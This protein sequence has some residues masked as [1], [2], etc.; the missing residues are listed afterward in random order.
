VRASLTHGNRQSFEDVADPTEATKRGFPTPR[1]F[2]LLKFDIVLATE[3]ETKEARKQWEREHGVSKG[4][5]VQR[6]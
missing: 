1:P 5:A 3:E 2:K 6:I 4:D